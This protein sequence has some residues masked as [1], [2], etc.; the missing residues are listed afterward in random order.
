MYILVG[1]VIFSCP[2]NFGLYVR[3]LLFLVN[4]N[5]VDTFTG[6]LAELAE[7]S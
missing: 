1:N 6:W 7:L 4:G 3:V 2:Q 5:G